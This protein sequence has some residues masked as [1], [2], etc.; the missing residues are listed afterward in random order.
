MRCGG[1]REAPGYLSTGRYENVVKIRP[2]MV[3]SRENSDMLLAALD[4]AFSRLC[5]NR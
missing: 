5:T 1:I 2:P 3:F 4:R